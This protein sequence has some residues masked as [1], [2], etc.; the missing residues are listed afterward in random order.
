MYVYFLGGPTW[1]VNRVGV[2]A[3]KV[4]PVI[5]LEGFPITCYWGI[6]LGLLPD[7]SPL[8]LK[9]TGTQDVVSLTFHEP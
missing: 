7:D 5:S 2:R 8:V 6:W 1:S 4:E 9:D 3:R